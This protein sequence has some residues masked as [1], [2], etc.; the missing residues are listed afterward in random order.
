MAASP[1]RG[2]LNR[3]GCECD[4]CLGGKRAPDA[5][6][7]AFAPFDDGQHL[8][9]CAEPSRA[10]AHGNSSRIPVGSIGPA[11]K[12]PSARGFFGCM[13]CR[14]RFKADSHQEDV[15]ATLCEF[16]DRRIDVQRGLSIHE[17][18]GIRADSRERVERVHASHGT[19]HVEKRRWN[20]AHVTVDLLTRR[21]VHATDA[22]RRPSEAVL[23]PVLGNRRLV[24]GSG[25]A[26]CRGK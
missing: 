8:V 11:S 24:V 22:G 19:I 2:R 10:T 20:S 26:E 9:E 6:A 12:W 3:L 4:G 16:S 25:D 7:H 13:K 17:G 15:A 14:H 1:R 23:D 21:R 5:V 18:S